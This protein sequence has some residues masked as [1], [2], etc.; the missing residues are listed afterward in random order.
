LIGIANGQDLDAGNV[1]LTGV[2]YRELV[3]S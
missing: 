3:R 1:L 2:L